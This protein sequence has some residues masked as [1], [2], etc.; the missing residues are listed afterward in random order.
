MEIKR[1]IKL[2][3]TFMP[4][5]IQALSDMLEIV[6]CAT[7]PLYAMNGQYMA[8]YGLTDKQVTSAVRLK[9]KLAEQL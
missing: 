3:V 2:A 8:S 7:D 6:R 1:E 4:E 9:Q 5:D